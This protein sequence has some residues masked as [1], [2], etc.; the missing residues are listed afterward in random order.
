MR[1]VVSGN[2][3]EFKYSVSRPIAQLK[4]QIKVIPH[5]V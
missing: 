4:I 1:R 5:K 3:N 2:K